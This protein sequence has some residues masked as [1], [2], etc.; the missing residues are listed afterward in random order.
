MSK[1][2][3]LYDCEKRC[4][5]CGRIIPFQDDTAIRFTIPLDPKSKKNSQK[6]V[7]F[8][9]RYGLTQSDIYKRYERECEQFIPKN[10]GV[11]TRPCNVKVLFYRQTKRKIDLSNL[12]AAIDDILV[13]YGV[14]S[15]DNR[16]IVAGH[17]GSAVFY[18]KLNPR[19]EITIEPRYNYE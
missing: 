11:I 19:L 9:N 14:L 1:I 18:D 12:Q 8:G 10:V 2:C 7:R 6:I 13:K 17:D 16:D 4:D 5:E 15:D 3:D